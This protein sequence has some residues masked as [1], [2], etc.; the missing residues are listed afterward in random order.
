[1]FHVSLQRNQVNGEGM[2]TSSCLKVT[3]QVPKILRLSSMS[4]IS[5]IT[6]LLRYLRVYCLIYFQAVIFTTVF[7]YIILTVLLIRGVT[8]P[9]SLEGI[10][11]YLRPDFNKLG[12]LQVCHHDLINSNN[13]III[14][15]LIMIRL[16][17]CPLGSCA[18]IWF[19]FRYGVKPLLR[20]LPR[21]L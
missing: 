6:S 9:G 1:M 15:L 5:I 2:F 12:K 14:Y 17:S 21:C 19:L 11:F 10:I 3:K 4:K 13:T 8:L 7:S 16:D 20:R 18:I